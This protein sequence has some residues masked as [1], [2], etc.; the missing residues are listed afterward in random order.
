M[1]AT[2]FA[3]D[4][5]DKAIMG[6]QEVY[7]LVVVIDIAGPCTIAAVIAHST[8]FTFKI[9]DAIFFAISVLTLPIRHIGAFKRDQKHIVRYWR[10][11][12]NS[13]EGICVNNQ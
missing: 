8:F 11:S 9:M 3:C 5:S 2:V 6:T 13:S 4:S 1:L 12:N 7:W 10:L